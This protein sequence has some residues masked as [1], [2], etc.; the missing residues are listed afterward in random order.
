[1]SI[2]NSTLNAQA[3]I[4]LSDRQGLTNKIRVCIEKAVRYTAKA[5]EF[6]I[7]AGQ[8]I[9]NAKTFW[10]D[11]WLQIVEEDCGLKRSRVYEILA[12]A[13]G[14]T[15]SGKIR[16]GTAKRVRDHRKRRVRYSNGQQASGKPSHDG[17]QIKAK[18]PL[19]DAF[20]K[21]MAFAW[22][23]AKQDEREQFVSSLMADE[24]KVET[25]AQ[26]ETAKPE[27]PTDG[28]KRHHKAV[29]VSVERHDNVV[30]TALTLSHQGTDIHSFTDLSREQQDDVIS[31]LQEMQ[32]TIFSAISRL[33]DTG[34]PPPDDKPPD[35]G[36][37][38]G[39]T[40]EPDA[41]K[42]TSEAPAQT[43]TISAV[44][45]K[46]AP[47]DRSLDIPD[48][49]IQAARERHPIAGP[50]DTPHPITPPTPAP[51]P[52]PTPSPTPAPAPAPER[53]RA[54]VQS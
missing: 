42:P 28:K 53:P 34:D 38:G 10:P 12:I 16:S 24:T 32:A 48:P 3:A 9:T 18:P 23:A 7:A 2:S 41:E 6:Y 25:P 11:H 8:Y 29:M 47:I 1:M 46:A 39:E 35:P 45:E 27:T 26:I 20:R 21:R 54:E 36:P 44:E 52:A 30:D 51:S 13:D 31:L 50:Q 40:E 4:A 5:E 33:R 14:R 17:E 49:L 37:T 15:T 43:G 22:A 19:A